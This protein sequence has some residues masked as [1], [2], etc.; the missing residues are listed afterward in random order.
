M[1]HFTIGLAIGL[2]IVS[3]V[4]ALVLFAG[5]ESRKPKERPRHRPADILPF[6]M[7][8]PR[9]KLPRKPGLTA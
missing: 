4:I 5:L 8:R 9:S 7:A 3:P 1:L 6:D 2:L